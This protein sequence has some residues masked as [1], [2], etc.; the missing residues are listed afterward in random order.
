MVAGK[1]LEDD[2]TAEEAELAKLTGVTA[3][4]A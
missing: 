4:Q 2:L 3:V 1:K